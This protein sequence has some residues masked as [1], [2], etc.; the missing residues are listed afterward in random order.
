[1]KFDKFNCGKES[2]ANEKD[3]V[4]EKKLDSDRSTKTVNQREA[5]FW[6]GNLR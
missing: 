4:E 1:M 3:W 6:L 2:F 5:S